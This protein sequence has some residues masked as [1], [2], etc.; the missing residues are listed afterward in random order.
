MTKPVLSVVIATLNEWHGTLNRTVE[1]IRATAGY[2]VEIVIVDDCSS[3]SVKVADC[4]TKVI[5]NKKRLGV[6]HSRHIGVEAASSDL[7]LLTD[8]HMVFCPGWLDA[9]LQ[10]LPGSEHLVLCG[11]CLALSETCDDPNHPEGDYNGAWM[12]I[13]DPAALPRWKI[14]TAKWA[15]DRLAADFYPLSAM[16]G[17][18][19]AMHRSWFLRIGGLRMLRGFGHDEELLSIKTIR[20][21]GSIRMFK[22]L[23]AGHVFRNRITKPPYRI[24][25]EE[26]IAN[27]I[28]TCL[29]CVP[30]PEASTLISALGSEKVVTR[31]IAMSMERAAEIT[32]EQERLAGVLTVS[33]SQYLQTISDIDR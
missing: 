33:W 29:T 23:K 19:Y 25:E 27:T 28:T 2:W 5:H 4:E 16:M 1:S 9:V 14:L 15:P 12:Q 20:A 26:S 11:K 32:L 10:T 8:S 6:G 21:G 3:T 7:I 22:S 31:A 18:L 13:Y 30:A 24:T 17:A